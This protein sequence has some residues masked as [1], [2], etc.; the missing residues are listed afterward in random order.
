MNLSNLQVEKNE[1]E[2]V[3]INLIKIQL[4]IAAGGQSYTIMGFDPGDV[5]PEIIHS[6]SYKFV[7]E[8]VSVRPITPI[9][10][11]T[12]S[13]HRCERIGFNYPDKTHK[14]MRT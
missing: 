9:L 2:L 8:R 10:V 11:T 3:L 13:G 7:H 6:F 5:Y 12:L 14:N 4:S 1:Q